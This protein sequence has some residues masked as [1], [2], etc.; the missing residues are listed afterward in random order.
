M[1]KKNVFFP[2][3]LL[4][5]GVADP[6]GGMFVAAQDEAMSSK[7]GLRKSFVKR[8]VKAAAASLLS[9][10]GKN[11]SPGR[12][13]EAAI[14]LMKDEFTKDA[15]MIQYFEQGKDEGVDDAIFIEDE[16][17]CFVAFQSTTSSLKDIGQNLNLK[18][19]DVCNKQGECCKFR[20]GF[21]NGW[22]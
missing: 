14:E 17:M 16:G 21:V 5:H 1:V 6:R 9:E 22:E 3:I 2:A 12:R 11:F 10:T 15:I 7:D 13:D 19:E 8:A 18:K 4:L 20:E